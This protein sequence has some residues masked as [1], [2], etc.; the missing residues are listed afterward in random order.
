MFLTRAQLFFLVLAGSGASGAWAQ[1]QDVVK[2]RASVG[3]LD[4]D[5]FFSAPTSAVSERVTS[6]TLGVNFAVPYSLQRFE[7]DASL[8]STQHQTNTNFDFTAQNYNAAWLWSV[9]PQLHGSL[10]SARTESLNATADSLNPN[11]RNKNTTQNTALAAAY[12]IGGP[13]QVTAGVSNTNNTNEQAVIGQSDTRSTGV[14]GGVRYV[15]G[16]GNSLAYF[17]QRASGT[18]VND[19]TSTTHDVAVVWV[20]TGNST[21][22]GHVAY[23][24]QRFGVAPQFDFSGASGSVMFVWRASGKVSVSAGWQRDLASYQTAGTTH[25]QTD[26]FTVAPAWQISPKTSVR[27]QYREGTRDDQGN[28]TGV[29][30]SRQ[31]RVRDT[32]LS[33]SW[34]PRPFATL[35]VSVGENNRTSNIAN[36]DFS[37]RTVGL[38]ALFSF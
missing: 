36:A 26:I 8:V 20:L 13:W 25:T 14:S 15:L 2:L 5:N 24:E 32:S 3:I 33:F 16:S 11:L 34:L 22:N 4:N 27:L 6:Q 31:D 18:S 21:V 37:A 1:T 30:T 10:T 17:L 23:L 19:F 12:E 38:T 29:P 7:L 28:P 9:T 35:S